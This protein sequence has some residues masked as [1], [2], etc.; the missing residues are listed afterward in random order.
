MKTIKLSV[1]AA[2]LSCSVMTSTPAFA[3]VAPTAQMQQTCSATN[4]LNPDPN[5]KYTSTLDP[6]SVTSSVGEE[7]ELSRTTTASTP[8]GVLLG[9]TPAVFI[10]G[11]EGRNGGSPNIFGEFKSTATYSGGS[12]S[13]T[14]VYAEDTEYTFGCIVSKTT[15]N[16]NVTTPPG[17]QVD[18]LKTTVTTTT[19]TEYVV[20]SAPNVTADYF[21]SGVICNSPLKNPGV[22]RNQNGYTGVCSTEKY[23]SLGTAFVHTN[24]VPFL[25]PIDAEGDHNQSR[26]D[27][28]SMPAS[29]TDDDHQVVEA[30][31][32]PQA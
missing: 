16:G 11:S 7:Y 28:I 21:T 6:A 10:A 15:N 23:L 12:L 3:Q 14:V 4:I 25:P 24:S 20:V 26:H 1:V 17:L 31:P 19:R 29:V 18:G 9:T 5:S 13:Q 32:E 22:W 2:L 8:S 27:E 30:A